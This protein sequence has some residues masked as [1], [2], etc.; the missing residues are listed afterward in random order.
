LRRSESEFWLTSSKVL[1]QEQKAQLLD[2]IQTWEQEHPDQVR[3]DSSRLPALSQL[4]S[5]QA[6]RNKASG[7]MA[8]VKSATRVGDQAVLLGERAMFMAQLMPFLVRL[9]VRVGAKELMADGAT[10]LVGQE[11]LLG[12]TE[13]LLARTQ[14]LV[15]QS[16]ELVTRTDRLGPI[17]GN[18]EELSRRVE[19]VTR[20]AQELTYSLDALATRFEPLLTPR[21]GP[22]GEPTTGLEA[23]LARSNDLSQRTLAVLKETRGLMPTGAHDQRWL[24]MQAQLD[25]TVRRWMAYLALVGAVWA[26]FFWGGYY[27]VRRHASVKPRRMPPSAR[28]PRPRHSHSS[29]E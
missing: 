3:V 9:Q 4:A 14:D 28:A 10:F 21:V 16:S 7:M 24:L 18:A 12:R 8:A 5:Q 2:M 13:E 25:R 23:V 11:A 15:L 27:L 1:S 6:E 26:V 29:A 20:E 19:S 17:L 22:G